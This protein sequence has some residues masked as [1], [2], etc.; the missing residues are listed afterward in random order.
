MT[1]Q[2][3][4]DDVLEI[5]LHNGAV[6]ALSR[7]V[8]EALL[9]GLE[10]AEANAT[11]RMI[12]IRGAG[13]LFSGGAD[14]REF[15]LD[16]M[17]GQPSFQDLVNRVEA[18]TKPVVA[19]ISG[20]CIG[21][22]LELA[23]ACHFRVADHSARLGLPEVTLGLLPGA[24]GTQRLPRLTGAARALDMMISGQPVTAETALVAGLIDH[25][26]DDGI[27]NIAQTLAAQTTPALRRTGALPPPADGAEA[28]AALRARL[29]PDA[30]S[31]A[32]ARICDCVAAI[33]PDYVPGLAV[34]KALFAELLASETSR[35]MRHA[36]FGER[37]VA[38]IPGNPAKPATLPIRQVGVLGGG[39]MGTGIAIALLNADL[40]VTLV[41]PREDGLA[42]AVATIS[43]TTRRDAEKGRIS[44]ETA[45]ARIARLTPTNAISALGDADLVIEA[46]FEDM[47]VKQQVFAELDRVTRANTIL[48][49]NTSTLDLDAIA[50]L[51]ADPGRVVG[52]HFFSPA[53]IMRLLEVVRGRDTRPEVLATAMSLAK[54]IGKVGVASGVCDGFIG[55]RMFEEYLRQVCFLLEEGALPRQIDSVLERWGF[56]MGPCRTMDLAGQDIGW[57]SRKRRAVEHPD[58]PYSGVIDRICEL[59][60][61]GQKTGKGIY[62]YPDGQTPEI[63]PEIDH[64]IVAY[65]AEIDIERREIGDVEIVSRCLLALI[66]EGAR[67]VG[68][69]IAY[70]PVDVDMV[71]LTGYGF[72]RERG[73]PLF[74]ADAMGL[75]QVLDRISTLT[76]GRHGWAWTP[77]PLLTKLAATGGSFADLNI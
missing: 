74:Q 22:G 51:V 24:G 7:P 1:R 12:V 28:V 53:N 76:A 75:A 25:L 68:E 77:A 16:D 32:P 19:A 21:G 56:A 71:W 29:R 62:R 3:L 15:A 48:G 72:A 10:A 18:C 38:R 64:L 40:P 39:L 30:L 47:A 8:R 37:Q 5:V 27:E 52:L 9:A 46:V 42:K 61:F 63:D 33:T 11:V 13:G 54:R 6:N 57:A 34:E 2:T 58:R 45:D 14:I 36:F 69:G 31:A 65:S 43:R 59:G 70:R 26:V 20:A 55:N 50:G 35:A 49:S 66:N 44:T 73:G 67:I 60:R 4:R 41:E 17:G 23:L